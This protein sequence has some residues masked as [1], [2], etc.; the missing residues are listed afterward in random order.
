MLKIKQDDDISTLY[1]LVNSLPL[2]VIVGRRGHIRYIGDP[3]SQ[4]KYEELVVSHIA[5][6]KV[7]VDVVKNFKVTERNI[8]ESEVRQFK[9]WCHLFER[10]YAELLHLLLEYKIEL[11]EQTTYYAARE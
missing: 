11:T 4:Q 8:N 10:E 9:M 6:S 3:L 2:Q 5:D 1:K 7:A